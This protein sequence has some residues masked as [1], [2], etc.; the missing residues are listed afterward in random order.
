MTVY[1]DSTIAD[2]ATIIALC[3]AAP[4]PWLMMN[5]YR[6]AT[7]DTALEEVLTDMHNDIVSHGG[8]TVGSWRAQWEVTRIA[9]ALQGIEDHEQTSVT[10]QTPDDQVELVVSI[11]GMAVETP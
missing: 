1:E 9:E 2:L 11:G 10:C 5:R 8:T 4:S 6:T 7:T 3:T